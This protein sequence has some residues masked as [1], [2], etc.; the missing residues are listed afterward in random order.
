MKYV[1]LAVQD[2]K[3]LE[4]LS[5][6]A[7]LVFEEACRASE[8]ELRH[9]GH[10][11]ATEDLQDG[12]PAAVVQV[13]NGKLSFVDSPFVQTKGLSIRLFFVH[14]RDLN[15][16]IQIAAKMPQARQGLIEVRRIVELE[17]ED[18]LE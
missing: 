10:L 18:V 12:S 16:A 4:A 15:A 14:A 6:A 7:R 8:Q 2:E 5:P 3:Q 17:P 13:Q 11:Y 9:D 1:F